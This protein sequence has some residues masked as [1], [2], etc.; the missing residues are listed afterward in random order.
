[1][2]QVKVDSLEHQ[3]PLYKLRT[4]EEA[5]RFWQSEF[6]HLSSSATSDKTKT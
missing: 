1:M 4:K 6:G 5:Q 3:H 2:L